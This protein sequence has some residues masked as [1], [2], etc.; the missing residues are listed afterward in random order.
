MRIW[1]MLKR[2]IHSR[3]LSNFRWKMWRPNSM[4]WRSMTLLLLCSAYTGWTMPRKP[5]KKSTSLWSQEVCSWVLPLWKTKSS[6]LLEK[7]WFFH[8]DGKINFLRVIFSSINSTKQLISTESPSTGCST[9]LVT[10]WLRIF[11]S[12]VQVR[13][14]LSLRAGSRRS[15]TLFTDKSRPLRK[16]S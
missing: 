5:L 16:R 14:L 11:I 7:K 8:P 13:W 2:T 15:D 6:L 4:T 10:R 3:T 9:A 1:A 12:I